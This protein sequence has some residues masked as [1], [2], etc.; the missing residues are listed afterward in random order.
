MSVTSSSCTQNLNE[1][2][3]LFLLPS[4]HILVTIQMEKIHG[5]PKL[6]KK[7][8]I[9]MKKKNSKD[10]SSPRNRKEKKRPLNLHLILHNIL[11]PILLLE[12]GRRGC[13]KDCN[14]NSCTRFFSSFLWRREHIII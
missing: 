11:S 6:K 10:T 9:Y 5:S 3:P 14:N 13:C 12:G 4:T 7:S 8:T 1:A 2:R